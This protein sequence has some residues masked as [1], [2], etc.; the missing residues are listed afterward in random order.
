MHVQRLTAGDLPKAMQ[1]AGHVDL[2]EDDEDEDSHVEAGPQ[3][4]PGLPFS[5]APRRRLWPDPSVPRL[6]PTLDRWTPAMVQDE[7]CRRHF[8]TAIP[9]P[10]PMFRPDPVEEARLRSPLLM[11]WPQRSLFSRLRERARARPGP[12]TRRTL[13]SSSPQLSLPLRGW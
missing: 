6:W 3:P 11:C 7:L 10:Q 2:P 4:Q 5:S 9:P 8:A 12:K 1:E 13:T